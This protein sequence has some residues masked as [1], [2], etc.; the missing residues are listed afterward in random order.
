M[1]FFS[2]SSLLEM[3]VLFRSLFPRKVTFFPGVGKSSILL[4]YTANEF[5]KDYNVTIGVEFGSKFVQLDPDTRVKLQV[6]DTV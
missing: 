4:K 3:L 1:T 5:R 6:W 2:N